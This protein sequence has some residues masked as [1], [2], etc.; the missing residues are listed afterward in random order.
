MTYAL[1]EDLAQRYGAEEIAQRESALDPGALDVILTDAD[2]MIDGYLISGYTLPLLPVPQKLTQVACAIARY[3]L[4]GDSVTER[5][6]NDYTDAV[7]WLGDVQ[8]GVVMLQVAAPVSD[9]A[10]SMVVI[11]EPNRSVFKRL[12][13]P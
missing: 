9:Y 13:R 2:A 1:R 6:R 4:L 10:P 8:S 7:T 12:G 11:A 3:N 5:S